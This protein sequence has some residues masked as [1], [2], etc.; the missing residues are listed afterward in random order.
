MHE[1][2]NEIRKLTRRELLR[3]LA[4]SAALTPFVSRNRLS[5]LQISK[6]HPSHGVPPTAPKTLSDQD[7]A[8]LQEIEAAN[9]RY[10]WE[11]ANPDTGIVRIAATSDPPRR[12]I[13]EASPPPDL[14]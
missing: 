8:F 6:E 7:D 3:S 14:D 13:W 10:F 9:F 11:Q 4:G 12:T 5:P 1:G 2:R